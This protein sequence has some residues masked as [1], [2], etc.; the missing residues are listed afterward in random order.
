MVFRENSLVGHAAVV[1]RRITF[2]GHIVEA[3]YVEG[4]A[5]GGNWRG[6]G[7]GS[8]LLAAATNFCRLN[9]RVSLLSTNIHKFYA[10]HGWQRFEGESFAE[11]DS[12]L[13]RTSE[14][15]D[16]LMLLSDD[17]MLARPNRVTCD[18]RRGDIW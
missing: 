6:L 14:D 2:D 16:G 12:G 7:L 3:G 18:F 8:E 15:D 10:K 9:Y 13:I 17:A 11:T 1:S 4:L 5:I